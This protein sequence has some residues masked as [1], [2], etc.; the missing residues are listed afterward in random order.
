MLPL[1]VKN[2]LQVHAC[3]P[4]QG[5]GIKTSQHSGP[6]NGPDVDDPVREDDNTLHSSPDFR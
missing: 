1:L 3:D 5:I 4:T 6:H 2:I